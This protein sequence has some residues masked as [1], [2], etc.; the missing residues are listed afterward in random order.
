MFKEYDESLKFGGYYFLLKIIGETVAFA[1]DMERTLQGLAKNL[2][3][4]DER[5]SKAILE[6]LEKKEVSMIDNKNDVEK[7]KKLSTLIKKLKNVIDC[8]HWLIHT[9]VL[10]FSSKKIDSDRL[11]LMIARSIKVFDKDN[12]TKLQENID[13]KWQIIKYDFGIQQHMSGNFIDFN[14]NEKKITARNIS[15]RAD[16]VLVKAIMTKYLIFELTDVLNNN[17][18]NIYAECRETINNA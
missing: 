6:L 5:N 13:G 4:K 8:R 11:F 16:W 15:G 7:I 17:P 12:L 2:F 1:Q 3:G 18:M 10:E 14:R 9:S